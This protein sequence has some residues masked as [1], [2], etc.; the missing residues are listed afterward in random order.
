MIL[1]NIESKSGTTS[2]SEVIHDFYGLIADSGAAQNSLG[3]SAPPP[4]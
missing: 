3:V 4:S 1:A 2:K